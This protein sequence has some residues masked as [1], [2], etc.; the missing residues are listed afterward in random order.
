MLNEPAVP[1]VPGACWQGGPR[2]GRSSMPPPVSP[3]CPQVGPAYLEAES[4]KT[5][6][7]ASLTLP[8]NLGGG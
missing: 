4:S 2:R 7:S 8:I 6:Q 5:G 3:D 1:T